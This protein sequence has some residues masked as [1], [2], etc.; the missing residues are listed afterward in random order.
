MQRSTPTW[1]DSDT[2]LWHTCR[3]AYGLETTNTLQQDAVATMFPLAAGERALA[4]GSLTIDEYTA[5]GDGTYQ[6]STF[7][8]GGTGAFGIALL[9][10]TAG[11]SAV[12]NAKKKAKA[13]RDAAQAWRHHTSG[14]ITV[15]DQGFYIHDPQGLWRWDWGSIDLL[16][17][18]EK[19]TVVMQGRSTRGPLTWRLSSDWAELVFVLWAHARHRQHPQY[20]TGEWVPAGWAQW[21]AELGYPLRFG[22]QLASE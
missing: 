18:A 17:V 1:T 10:A 5:A 3:I 11:G 20:L 7:I 2:A 16:Q 4:V 8:A 12:A 21:A 15:T 13:A 9:A 19:R 22:G 14:Q 6:R